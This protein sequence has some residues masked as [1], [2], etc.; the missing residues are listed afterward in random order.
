M[1]D[2]GFVLTERY[3]HTILLAKLQSLYTWQAHSFHSALV[4]LLCVLLVMKPLCVFGV[5]CSDA[6]L[7]YLATKYDV[8]DHWYPRQPERRAKVDEYTAWHH[9]YT[10]PHAA[11]VFI[12]EV[13]THTHTFSLSSQTVC[14]NQWMFP[15]KNKTSTRRVTNLWLMHVTSLCLHPPVSGPYS[16]ADWLSGGWGAFESCS[17]S[18]GRHSGQTGDHVPQKTA[19]P[20]WPWHHPGRLAR[21]LWDNAGQTLSYLL[22]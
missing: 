8:P 1:V 12:Q 19:F 7:K 2:N 4:W 14:V 22:N 3:T 18:A 13:H 21:R 11:R 17:V 20:L 5:C 10:R 15:H 16:T 6:I 9:N